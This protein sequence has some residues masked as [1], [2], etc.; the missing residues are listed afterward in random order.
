MKDS[1]LLTTIDNRGVAR[2]TLNRPEV[3][4]A[5]NEKL[6]GALCDAMARLSTDKN[7]RVIVLT[8][9]GSTF[10]AGADLDMMRR[11]ADYSAQENKD[12]ARR[13]GHMLQS[14][15]ACEKPTVALVNGAA[16]GGGVG[17]VA[18]CD[19]AIAAEDAVF[20]LTEVRVGL[21]PAV[22]SPFVMRAMGVRQAR[23]YFMTGERFDAETARRISL[24]HMVS[25]GAQLEATLDGVIKDLLASGP[26]AQKEVKDLIR[27]VAFQPVDER[28]MEET[29]GRIARLRA[30]PEGKEGVLSFLEK[31]KPD[32]V[33]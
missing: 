24:V 17:I 13:L 16:M 18:A 26:V 20:G 19:I 29:A 25:M 30:S 4:N 5:F 32:W 14:I 11:V 15:Y 3:R 6:I 28:I 8:G 33:K 10:C 23:R 22:I 9:A 12:D 1:V 2:L 27:A 31:R 21:I 7:V